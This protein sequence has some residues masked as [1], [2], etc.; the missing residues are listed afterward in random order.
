MAHRMRRLAPLAAAGGLLLSAA[1]GAGPAAAGDPASAHG[2]ADFADFTPLSVSAG[3]TADEAVPL[4]LGNPHMAQRSMA[5]R[6]TQ[7]AAGIPNSG[8]W[9]V[10]TVN[11]TGRRKGQ[12]L[13][14]VFETG[15]A[16]V[17][18]TNLETGR[19]ETIWYSPTPGGH[20]AFDASYWTP[21]GTFIT[22]EE[23][24]CTNAAGCT[25][26]YGRLFE[27]RN[28]L[29]APGITGPA[30]AAANAGADLVHRNVVPR[31]S[32]EGIQFDKAGN[33]YF[34]DELNG[35]S[36]YR[37]TPA[38]PMAKVMNGKADY[39]TAGQT[40]V[41]RVGDGATPNATGAYT[42]V[43]ITDALGAP[44]PGA[45]SIA[46]GNGVTS[47]D[48]RNTTDLAAFK[49]T[50]Y[51]R[52]EDLQ[53]AK[54]EGREVLY[55]ATTTTNEVYRLDLKAQ[56]ISVYA[57]RA[58]VDLATGAAVD[59]GL[60]SPDNLALDHDGNIYIIEDR[61]GGVDDDIWLAE[62]RNRDGD[63]LDAG[64]GIG[65]WA[66]NGTPGSELTG[67]YFDPFDQ[68][69]AWVNIQHPTSANDRLI[70]LTVDSGHHH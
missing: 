11:E 67:L 33:M 40:A 39:F 27:L 32:H 37:Y 49:G 14:T 29:D 41:L 48:A 56:T 2:H 57:N 17:Q 66:S 18:R 4:T 38:A 47:V 36:L 46:D 59:A 12:F 21:W 68:H 16:G 26:N 1:W 23:S 9:D 42:W 28:P 30:S 20:V 25:S 63:L 60:A 15:Q 45:I 52:P 54:E 65:R 62:D 58:T 50:D 43:P 22:A 8:A 19:T 6:N 24:W 64:E 34:I 5:D 61:N 7:L 53:I 35:G 55:V 10:I 70:E 69:R 31:T 44:L 3:P 51:Q 13:F